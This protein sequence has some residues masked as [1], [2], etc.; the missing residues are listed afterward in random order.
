V[1][2]DD[3]LANDAASAFEELKEE[4][5]ELSHG[6]DLEMKFQVSELLQNYIAQC[7]LS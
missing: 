1:G 7:I 5:N 6:F 3:D 2:I 4:G